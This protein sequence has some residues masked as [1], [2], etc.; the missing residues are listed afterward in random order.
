[1]YIVQYIRGAECM[2]LGG[3]SGFESYSSEPHREIVWTSVTCRRCTSKYVWCVD[4]EMYKSRYI[5]VK[6]GCKFA[7]KWESQAWRKL[8][9]RRMKRTVTSS[10][11]SDRKPEAE[12]VNVWVEEPRN[13]FQIYVLCWARIFKRLWSRGIV[14][15]EWIPPAYV[16]WR[17]G[18]I[19]LFLL[20]A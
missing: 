13:R 7:V 1:M 12:F 6:K 3:C 15:K 19:T 14:S 17:T 9:R 11:I 2:I 4:M 10:L 18:T 5:S 8:P 16:A 20:G